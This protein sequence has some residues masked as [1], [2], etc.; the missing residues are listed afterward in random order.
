[1]GDKKKINRR[2]FIKT[3]AAGSASLALSGGFIEKALSAENADQGN[4]NMMPTRTLGKTGAQ[5]SIL[6]MGGSVDSS[7][8]QT[9]LRVGLN[10][11]IN[12]WDS[13]NSYGNGRNEQ[14]IGEF[15]SKYPEDRKKVFQVTKASRTTEPKRMSEQLDISL[16]RMQTDYI[17]LYFIHMLQDPGLLTPEIKAWAE[18]KKKEGKIK[19]FGFSCHANM[20][21]MLTQ[22]ANL[23]WIDALMT[24]YNYQLM[25]N[26]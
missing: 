15:F 25:D 17:D 5:V 11:G 20:P 23:G 16:E 10:M 19:F 13:A 1:M 9:L 21:S 26:D 7:G 6:G 14:I 24:S 4:S 8:Y 12:Y 3:A 2:S 22:A 18:Q